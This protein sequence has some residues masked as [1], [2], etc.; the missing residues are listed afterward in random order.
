M[1]PFVT[2]DNLNEK[3]R[4]WLDLINTRNRPR[5]D[6]II[7]PSKC[8]LIVVDMMHYFAH[9]DGRG[10]L[11]AT[12]AIIPEISRLLQL[13]RGFGSTVVFT[14]HCHE[15]EHDLGMLGKFFSDYI[16]CG[17]RESDIISEITPA[18]GEK[19]F[20]KNTYDA[21]HGTGLEKYLRNHDIEQVLVTGVLTQLCCETAARSAFVR[22]FEVYI[23]ADAMTT[24]TEELHIG[25][26]LGLASGFAIVSDTA[27]ICSA[28]VR[29]NCLD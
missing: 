6:L 24:S 29:K 16:H 17:M 2:P 28:S 12:N 8:A 22:G 1:E 25:S 15:G 21:F 9:P 11:P 13:W 5:P 14:K 23:A 27:S 18:N 7:E 20:H 3:T 19:V 4:R 26:L 10:Y